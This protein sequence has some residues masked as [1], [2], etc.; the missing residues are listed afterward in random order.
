ML[1]TAASRASLEL[2]EGSYHG[3]YQVGFL[4]TETMETM[5]TMETSAPNGDKY[6]ST[7]APCLGTGILPQPTSLRPY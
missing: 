2:M 4:S 3:F 5:E 1:H 7:R 6:R